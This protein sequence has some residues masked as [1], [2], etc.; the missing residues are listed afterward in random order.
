VAIDV[1]LLLHVPPPV[2]SLKL[3]VRPTQTIGL[4]VMAGGKEFTITVA[5]AVQP[6]P[7]E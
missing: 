3:V 7:R 1:L 6:T 4:P 5:V 2:T